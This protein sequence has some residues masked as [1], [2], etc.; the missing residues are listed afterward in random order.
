MVQLNK[1]CVFCAEWLHDAA[2]DVKFAANAILQG[3][4]T[5]RELQVAISAM[6]DGINRFRHLESNWG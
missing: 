1:D 5:L 2:E 6:E 4:G 3:E